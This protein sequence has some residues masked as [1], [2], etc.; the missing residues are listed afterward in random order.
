VRVSLGWDTTREAI[1]RLLAALPA[2]LARVK[3]P[4]P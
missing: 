1:E 2:L 4:F 3:V